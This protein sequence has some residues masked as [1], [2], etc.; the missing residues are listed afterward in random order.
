M[1]E[2]KMRRGKFTLDGE[3]MR[4][5]DFEILKFV[6]DQVVVFHTEAHF[7]RDEITY[8]AY[9]PSFDVLPYGHECPKYE[10]IVTIQGANEVSV[11]WRKSEC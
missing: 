8:F 11:E 3:M 1:N 9:H 10:A 4:R 5:D 7:D 2:E 6:M